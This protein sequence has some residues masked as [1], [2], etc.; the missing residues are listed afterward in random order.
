MAASSDKNMAEMLGRE[1]APAVPHDDTEGVCERGSKEAEEE[2]AD[3]LLPP[4]TDAAR[5]PSRNTHAASV[6]NAVSI[7]KRDPRPKFGRVDTCT[8]LCG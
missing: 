2:A 6:Q 3:L 4:K 7:C 1:R 8:Q 5:R